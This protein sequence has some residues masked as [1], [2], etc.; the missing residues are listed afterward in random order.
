MKMFIKI[1]ISCFV[2]VSMVFGIGAIPFLQKPFSVSAATGWLSENGAWYYYNTAGVKVKG[3]ISVNGYWYYLNPNSGQMY[4]GWQ[5][6][7][8]AWYQFQSNG[9]MMTGWVQWNGYWYY[10]NPNS[11]AKGQALTDW[12]NIDGA[13]YFFQSNGAMSTGWFQ[14]N[15]YWYY[16]NPNSPAQGQAL[17]GWQQIGGA[18]HF[19]QSNG[20]MSTGWFQ[21]NGYWYYLNPNASRPGQAQTGWLQIGGAWHFFQ[22]NGAMITGWYQWNGY[23]YYLNPNSSRPGQMY[24]GWQQIGGARY[25][26]HGNGVMATGWLD[27]GGG[28][29]YYLNGNG[30][31]I[32]G[33]NMID[34]IEYFFAT[35]GVYD[36]RC[37]RAT[38]TLTNNLKWEI[39]DVQFWVSGTASHIYHD[40]I[41]SAM[42]NWVY[43]G[44][45]NKLSPG[46][47]TGI[48]LESAVEFYIEDL[49]RNIRGSTSYFEF[50]SRVQIPLVVD[51]DG[52]ITGVSK[53]W[54]YCE[55]TLNPNLLPNDNAAER[56][57]SQAT[58]THE[59]G[60][61]FG[62]NHNNT[63]PFSIMFPFN[64]GRLSNNIRQV[65]ND[66]FKFKH[67]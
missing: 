9:P 21:S 44:F 13:W 54:D 19:F 23:W 2:C 15:G 61:V 65:D 32:T 45:G 24:I 59:L 60:H 14:S 43:T 30:V 47:N 34:G 48:R 8:G 4:T 27:L 41:E 31:M 36:S 5:K 63:N 51:S 49:G 52:N 67:P 3:W 42:T 53:N 55:I 16:L 7:D 10:L 33:Y 58:I 22:S 35:N 64:E 38:P 18:W 29:K 20:A 25:Y 50:G 39:N 66:A 40:Q 1:L 26:F 6:I 17:T 37:R 28:V 46:T 56:I 57:S 62:L 11:P 12:Q